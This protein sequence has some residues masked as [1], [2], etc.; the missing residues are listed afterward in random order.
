MIPVVCFYPTAVDRKQGT[1]DLANDWSL[2][3]NLC[4]NPYTR[5]LSAEQAVGNTTFDYFG[6]TFSI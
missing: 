3:T 6:G 2:L 1:H 5:S 4:G